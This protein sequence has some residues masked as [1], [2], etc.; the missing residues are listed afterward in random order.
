MTSARGFAGLDGGHIVHEGA[1]VE[2][3]GQSGRYIV[4]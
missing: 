3:N 2:V 4:L 1:E